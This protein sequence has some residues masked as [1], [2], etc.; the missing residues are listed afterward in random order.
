[1]IDKHRHAQGLFQEKTARIELLFGDRPRL[2]E[3]YYLVWENS[4]EIVVYYTM[5]SLAEP[6]AEDDDNFKVVVV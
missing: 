3:K 2:S 1:M 4:S 6:D 5:E